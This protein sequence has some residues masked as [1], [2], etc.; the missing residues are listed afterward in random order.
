MRVLLTIIGCCFVLATYGQAIKQSVRIQL[1]YKGGG[2]FLEE[3]IESVETTSLISKS[4][5]VEYRAGKT[6]QLL[7]GFEAKSG[8]VFLATVRP[9]FSEGE[10]TLHLSAFPNPFE[11]VTT[12]EY[13]L[14]ADGKVDLWILD[15][16]GVRV[17]QLIKDQSQ[18]AGMHRIEWNADDAVPGVYL[19]VVESNQQRMTTR[20]VKK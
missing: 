2:S 12:I 1:E 14:P 10:K 20:L 11:H 5:N 18:A 13:Y 19:P 4:A 17:R 8:S 3:A 15:A 7:P 9:V 6:V 16:Q